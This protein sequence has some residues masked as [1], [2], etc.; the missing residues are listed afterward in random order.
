MTYY[1]LRFDDINNKMNWER[2]YQIKSVINKHKIK[3][4]LG[5]IPKCDDPE[6]SKFPENK[7]YISQLQIMKSN[8]DLI[9]Q[10][11]YR[12]ITDSKNIGL[13]GNERRSEFA[14]LD[15]KT[16]YQRIDNLFPNRNIANKE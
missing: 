15:Y 11:G 3:S 5:V 6:I 16:Q 4:I 13:Y 2:F 14:G 10:H 12:H 1:L 7:N 9:A 8:G